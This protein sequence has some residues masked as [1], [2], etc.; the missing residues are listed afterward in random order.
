MTLTNSGPDDFSARRL[1]AP[2]PRAEV[3]PRP[4]RASMKWTK[5]KAKVSETR[6]N[7]DAAIIEWEA[8]T[9]N[10]WALF[11]KIEDAEQM[12]E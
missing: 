12:T 7:Q 11:R 1:E 9:G 5:P 6:L 2:L 4:P 8:S 10:I 3:K